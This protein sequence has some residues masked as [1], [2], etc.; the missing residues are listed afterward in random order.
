MS[1]GHASETPPPSTDGDD[2]RPLFDDP[3]VLAWF[4]EHAM[5]LRRDAEGQ[6]IL[7]ATLVV[8][9]VI[10]LLAYVAGYLLRSAAPTEPLALLADLSYTFGYALWTGV[11]IVVFVQLFPEAKRRQYERALAA[12]EAI[13]RDT[14]QAEDD[15]GT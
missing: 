9:F 12:Y 1:D 2:L 15:G 8:G 7:Y 4:D 10:G 11:V 5:G 6:R 3:R 13:R 14:A